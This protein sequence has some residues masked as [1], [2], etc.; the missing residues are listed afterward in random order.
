[1]FVFGVDVVAIPVNDI[2][3]VLLGELVESVH[4]VLDDFLPGARLE[5]VWPCC[6]E[7]LAGNLG[8]VEESMMDSER[9]GVNVVHREKA[10]RYQNQY[11][12]DSTDENGALAKL[13]MPELHEKKSCQ[14][15]EKEIVA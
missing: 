8:S 2:V 3:L 7:V 1:M 14:Y 4:L 9:P 15:I 10:E 13:D 11:C 6:F 5:V 12:V